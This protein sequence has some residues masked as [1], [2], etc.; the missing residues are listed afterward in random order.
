MRIHIIQHVAFEGPGAIREWARERGHL[1]T[2]TDQSRG[3]PLPALDTFDFLVVMGGPMSA[4]DDSRFAWLASEKQLIAEAVRGPKAVLGICLGA[5]LLAQVMGA[6]VYRNREK[7]IGWFPVRL[8]PEAV[9]GGLF[10]GLPAEMT[11]LHWH[12]ET[13]DLPPGA[14]LLAE[15]DVCRNQAFAIGRRVLGLQ[16]HMEVQPQ[17][18]ED[19]IQNSAGDLERGPAVQTRGALR[20]SGR[21]AQTLRPSLDAILDRMAEAAGG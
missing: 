1:I 10:A 4:N 18:L 15:S 16:F 20:G 12:G 7:E 13:F 17:G 2:V 5:Q 6:R 19:L 3:G 11:V 14:V 9:G 8:T 21:L